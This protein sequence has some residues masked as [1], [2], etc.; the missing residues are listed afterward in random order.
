MSFFNNIKK[1][2]HFGGNDAKKKKVYNNV[3][4]ECDPEEFWDMIGELG[5][6]AYGKVYKAQHRHTGQLA[7][8]KMCRLDGE[9]DLADFMIEIDILSEIKHQNIV[10]L[11]EAFQKEQQLWLLIEYCDGGALD[12]IMTELE[13]P[14]NE[15]QIAYVCQNMCKGLQFL[16]KSHIIH[17]DLK[18]GNV[19]L[20][21]AGGVKLADF[22][23]SAKNKNTLQ[24]HDTFIGTP[25]WMAPEVVLCET[26]R[27][28]PYDYKVDIWSMGIT[29]IEFAQ[30]EPPNHEMSPMRVLLKIQK[31]E[32]PKL[33]QPSKWSKEFNDFLLKALIKD[34]QKRPNCEEL[35]KHPFINCTLDSKPLK[36]L[37]LEYKAEVV[38]EELTD[39]DPEDNRTSQVPLDIE[40]DSASVRSNELDSKAAPKT[41]TPLP[42]EPA[43]SEKEDKIKEPSASDVK[44]EASSPTVVS[45]PGK[46]PLEKKEEVQR[47]TSRDKGKAPPPPPLQTQ[48]STSST[49]SAT[50]EK[51]KGPA[52][53][54]PALPI[55]ALPTPPSSPMTPPDTP[56][57]LRDHAP[58][59]R[60]ISLANQQ[61]PEKDETDDMTRNISEIKQALENH[62][63][64]RGFAQERS[65]DLVTVTSSSATTPDDSLCLAVGSTPQSERDKNTSTITINS[66]L[67][68]TSNSLASNINQVTVV[69]THPPVIIDNSLPP[70]SRLSPTSTIPDEVVIVSNETNKTTRVNSSSSSAASS[71]SSLEEA[72]D[73]FCPSL[74]SLEYP[75]PSQFRDKTPSRFRDK[76]PSQF[77]DKTPSQFGD[78]MPLAK[79]LDESEVMITDASYV[80]DDSGLDVGEDTSRLLDT[81]HVSVVKIDEEKVQVHDS[82]SYLS[83]KSGDSRGSTSD[84]SN[85]SSG[86]K[87]GSTKSGEY[88]GGTHI[89]LEGGS[90]GGGGS[91]AY[92]L[93][94]GGAAPARSHSREDDYRNRL[95]NGKVYSES[96]ESA[97]SD[98]SHSDCGSVRSTDS[99][100]RP[101]SGA[102]K[103]LEQSDVESIS[104]ASQGSRGSNE[105]EDKRHVTDSGDHEVEV[106]LRKPPKTKAETAAMQI[107]KTRKRTRKFV[108]DGVLITTT[109]SKVIYGDEDNYNLSDPHSDRKQ[110]LRELKYLQKQEQKQFQDLAAKEQLAIEQQD[111]KFE[112]ERATLERTFEN[113]LEMLSRQQRAQIER[114]EAH[115]D[116]DLRATS[117]KIRGEQERDLKQFRE[118][119]KAEL[120]LL[121]YEVDMLP[122]ERR[123]AEFKVRKDKMDTEHLDREKAFL[124]KLNENHESSLRRLSDAHREKIALMER[125]FLQQKQQLTRT[126]E[127]ALWEIE[128]RHIHEKH[129]LIKR[130]IKEIFIL[131]RH[132]M[133][134]RHEKEKEQIK[135]RASRK[136]E[137]LLKKQQIERRSLP[138]RIRAEMKA[139]E[140][141]FRESMRISVSVGAGDPD[142]EKN[143]FK[144]FQDKEKKRYQAEQQRFELKHQ[145]QL[146]ELRAMSDATI[147]ELEQLQNEKRKMLLE[148]ETLKLKQREEAFSIEFKEW[149]A[150]LK[151]RKQKLEE[152]LYRAMRA[153]T[154]ADYLPTVLFPDQGSSSTD[155]AQGG[156]SA[157][158][159]QGASSVPSSPSGQGEGGSPRPSWGHQRTWSTGV[160][161]PG[162]SF[163]FTTSSSGPKHDSLA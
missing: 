6:G 47:K 45:Q 63:E 66:N 59:E 69:T 62:I 163:A 97:M 141:M 12:S 43:S 104:L 135:R 111:R 78:K 15:H 93:T 53:P 151:P 145:R 10:E 144:E 58:G 30:M 22:G 110:E 3:R 106:V 17:R 101:I 138:K 156:S 55:P 54:P 33:E 24:K 95:N 108:I 5:D 32:P 79:R 155:T 37:L 49:N 40:D 25:Y 129:Q 114:A 68:D 160:M 27:D 48:Q 89:L 65:G 51:E 123:K 153:A 74:D 116:A 112:Q 80:I 77:R 158:V 119:L 16:H 124:E 94:N 100:R 147:K 136:E 26:F 85:T 64:K 14:L 4:M 117:K 134:T 103:S 113:D 29:L 57:D 96:F 99:H 161:P 23:V 44:P 52:P 11:H 146:E 9:D 139:R 88:G 157:D 133:L 128:E 71:S 102:S 2:L 81:S 83:E 39:D 41:S 121:K 91:L 130:Q 125:Q 148:H 90:T 46:K 152:E 67:P 87:S 72:E 38:E 142:L 18:A 107:R 31:S 127:A 162:R 98:R 61:V 109:T 8:A 34:P 35:L 159:A 60:D 70:S 73:D 56:P 126:R 122:K 149:K 82:T 7:A 13:K 105:K 154:Y 1:V 84:L 143:R 21:M 20:T 76:P 50:S 120:R 42:I 118:G 131:Q 75:P 92:H 140:A 150:K 137:E 28:N 86:G 36:D 132:Q 115:Q 19:L